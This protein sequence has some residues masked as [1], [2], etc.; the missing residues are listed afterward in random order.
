[1]TRW[2]NTVSKEQGKGQEVMIKEM[3]S[4]GERENSDIKY[5]KQLAD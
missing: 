5:F 4:G 3:E 2:K 1:M